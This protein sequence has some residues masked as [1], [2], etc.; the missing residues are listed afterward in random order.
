[1]H[2]SKGSN[3]YCSIQE[4]YYNT[5]V[6]DSVCFM[7]LYMLVH[8]HVCMCMTS[9]GQS[10]TLLSLSLS[11]LYFERGPLAEPAAHWL[12][13]LVGQQTLWS[14]SVLVSTALGLQVCHYIM[15]VRGTKL[16][17]LCLPGKCFTDLAIFPGSVL[18]FNHKLYR[19]LKN[20]FC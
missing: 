9:W 5:G 4:N 13:W 3:S 17:S 19:D 12:G 11:T 1:M 20:H 7:C 18:S 14:P 6:S 16:R 15:W 8:V 10:S 2:F